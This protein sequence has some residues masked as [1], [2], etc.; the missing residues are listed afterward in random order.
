MTLAPEFA[1]SP[2]RNLYENPDH[3]QANC[4]AIDMTTRLLRST[5]GT[6]AVIKKNSQYSLL[7]C[8]RAPHNSIGNQVKTIAVDG[9]HSFEELLKTHRCIIPY[10]S[11]ATQGR[12]QSPTG[13]QKQPLHHRP[14]TP[15]QLGSNE[16][17][18]ATPRA[19]YSERSEP[20][21]VLPAIIQPQHSGRSEPNRAH[22][23]ATQQR[24]SKELEAPDG[25]ILWSELEGILKNKDITTFLL[26]LIRPV[27]LI[28]KNKQDN[29]VLYAINLKGFIYQLKLR[30]HV[31]GRC[32]IAGKST[33]LFDSLAQLLAYLGIPD[34]KGYRRAQQERNPEMDEN[35]EALEA[36]ATVEAE[37]VGCLQ[38]LLKAVSLQDPK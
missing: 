8:A 13:S 35:L 24:L 14:P 21:G 33:V 2:R 23:T 3:Y 26:E 6:F 7:V 28:T 29:Y 11:Q 1:L 17:L 4:T 34:L 15:K 19:Q 30:F 22:P 16:I 20:N 32:H 31:D 18:P 27:Y 10:F 25:Y 36:D 5:P 37:V 9:T 38:A 12:P